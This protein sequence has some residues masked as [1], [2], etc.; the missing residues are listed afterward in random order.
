MADIEG[1]VDT[2]G[3][4]V[5]YSK[6]AKKYFSEFDELIMNNEQHYFNIVQSNIL[7]IK[8]DF[9]VDKLKKHLE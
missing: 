8:L 9:V 2:K 3:N 5:A 1:Y 7:D 6:A 4:V